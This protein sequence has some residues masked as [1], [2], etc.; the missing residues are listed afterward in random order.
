MLSDWA[1]KD[2]KSMV[3]VQE[4]MKIVFKTLVAQQQS[5]IFMLDM[6]KTIKDTVL[7]TAHSHDED[8]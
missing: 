6:M 2:F 1:E 5:N 4:G 3:E 8:E 7:K